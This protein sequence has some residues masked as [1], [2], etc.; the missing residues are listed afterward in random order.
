MVSVQEIRNAISRTVAY[1]AEFHKT[2]SEIQRV[3]FFEYLFP[4]TKD[5]LICKAV[6]DA[7]YGE[8]DVSA[9]KSFIEAQVDKSNVLAPMSVSEITDIYEKAKMIAQ[10]YLANKSEYEQRLAEEQQE[11]LRSSA[12]EPSSKQKT[13]GSFAMQTITPIAEILAVPA[14]KAEPVI[15]PAKKSRGAKIEKVNP[16]DL[17]VTRRSMGLI[18]TQPVKIKDEAALMAKYEASLAKRRDEKAFT[19]SVMTP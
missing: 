2:A 17:M 6:Y 1:K 7:M 3:G 5:K 9:Q 12:V 19:P 11:M 15:K 18:D 13:L 4:T 8:N 14:Q 10:V 16:V